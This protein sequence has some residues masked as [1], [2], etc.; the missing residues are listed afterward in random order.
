MSICGWY[1]DQL[2][3]VETSFLLPVNIG[4]GTCFRE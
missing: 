1:M 2:V 4:Q 3:R